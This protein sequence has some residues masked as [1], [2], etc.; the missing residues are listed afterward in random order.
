MIRPESVAA[1]ERSQHVK[2]VCMS[3]SSGMCYPA[4]ELFQ[5]L[6]QMVNA[7][8]MDW[9]FCLVG[10][11]LHHPPAAYFQ[12]SFSPKTLNSEDNA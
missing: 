11:V 6:E 12:I 5:V 7:A 9:V 2:A 3:S 8:H 10:N 4:K 1:G